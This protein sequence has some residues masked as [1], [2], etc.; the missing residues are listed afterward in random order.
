MTDPAFMTKVKEA[1]SK[2]Q[3]WCTPE[4]AERLIQYVIEA[5]ADPKIVEIGVFGGS[6][7]VA[8]GLAAQKKGGNCKVYGIDPWS[9]DAALEDMNSTVNREWWGSIDM[10]AVF[11]G[12]QRLMDIYGLTHIVELI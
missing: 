9:T 5:P 4:K 12:C 7:L 10:N 2:A 3:G 1:L 6:S 11:V 8:L